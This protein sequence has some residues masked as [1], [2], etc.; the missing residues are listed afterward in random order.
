MVASTSGHEASGL[1]DQI[2][3]SPEG[4]FRVG[5]GDE[6]GKANDG[7]PTLVANIQ[8]QASLQL[9]EHNDAGTE[10]ADSVSSD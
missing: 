1:P 8:Q 7:T 3:H 5:S 2:W 6:V 4:T 9:Q 10:E